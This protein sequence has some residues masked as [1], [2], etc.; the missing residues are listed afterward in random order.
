[1][2]NAGLGYLPQIQMKKVDHLPVIVFEILSAHGVDA[3][4][5][6]RDQFLLRPQRVINVRGQ[7]S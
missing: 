7:K 2:N 3:H 4:R 1:M 5:F 6:E